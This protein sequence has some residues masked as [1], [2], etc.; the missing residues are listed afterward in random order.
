MFVC[1]FS[2]IIAA[3]KHKDLAWE[4][5]KYLTSKPVQTKYSA[6]LLPMW[7]TAYADG[8]ELDALL[9]INPSNPVTV[10]MFKEQF[11]FSH[12]RPKVPFYPEASKALQLAMQ[13]ALTKMKSPKE[14][15][16]DAAAKWL[17]LMK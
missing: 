15:L 12:V 7:Q 14:A 9:A 4:Y 8:P 16:D 17:S 1:N 13:E 5:V 10:P 6:H 3:S 11:P 2:P